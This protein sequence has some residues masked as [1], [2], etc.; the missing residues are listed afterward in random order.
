MIKLKKDYYFIKE[1]NFVVKDI[2]N[3]TMLFQWNQESAF[4][5]SSFSTL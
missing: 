5:I 4:H 1:S 2:K 3:E